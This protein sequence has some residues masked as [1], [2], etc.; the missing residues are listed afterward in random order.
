MSAARPSAYRIPATRAGRSASIVTG[1]TAGLVSKS[2]TSAPAVPPPCSTSSRTAFSIAG[3]ASSRSTP[4]SHRLDASLCSLC[5]RQVRATMTGSQCAASNSTS[6]VSGC[7]SDV[8]PPITAA[9]E[10]GP[11]SS[12]ITMSSGS[13]VRVT[14]SSVVSFS[15]AV[16]RRTTSGPVRRFRSNACMGCPNSSIR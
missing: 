3:S 10:I 16:A 2:S 4:R 8:S 13:S 5:R 9:S 11:V 12:Q 6:T 7:T 15:P 1:A 14:L